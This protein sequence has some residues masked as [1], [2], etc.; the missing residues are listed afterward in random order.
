[1]S[2]NLNPIFISGLYRSGTTSLAE[3]IDNVDSINVVVGSIH[4]MRLIEKFHPIEKNLQKALIFMSNEYK[5]KWKK[6]INININ[7]Y[8]KVK[9]S[10]LA[11]IY[12]KLIRELLNIGIN[13]RWAEKTNVQWESIPKFLSIFPKGQVIHIYR[14]PRSVAASFKFF[15]KHK[16]PM[17]LDSVFASKAM[18]NYLDRNEIFLKNKRIKII[19]FE[20]FFSKK[21]Q[22]ID[23]LLKFL[24]IN[25]LNKN[26]KF[27]LGGKNFTYKNS[28][29]FLYTQRK[30]KLHFDNSG[31]IL[32]NA[33]LY[34]I[35]KY[36]KSE[37]KKFGYK[38]LIIKMSKSDLIEFDQLCNNVYL[39]PRIKYVSKFD[40]GIQGFPEDTKNY[41]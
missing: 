7:N 4:F 10:D 19:K 14:D 12:D 32:S 17:F 26:T 35:Q 33:E 27:N 3:I 24:K 39:K 25:S 37:I 16:Y 28:S 40:N 30:K 34:F 21:N 11:S 23:D 22:S 29:S 15:T 13:Y 1:M 20:N 38:N 5:R 9:K 8:L 41:T 6:N 18:F 2:N 31:K 36:L